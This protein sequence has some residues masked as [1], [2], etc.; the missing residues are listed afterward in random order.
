MKLVGKRKPKR[1]ISP[2][3]KFDRAVHVDRRVGNRRVTRP[4]TRVRSSTIRPIGTTLTL[5]YFN[6]KT[7]RW[8]HDRRRAVKMEGYERT[9]VTKPDRRKKG[10]KYRLKN[11]GTSNGN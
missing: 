6:E 3:E 4:K 11:L 1:P 2:G 7:G 9:V 5:Q 8:E 10:L